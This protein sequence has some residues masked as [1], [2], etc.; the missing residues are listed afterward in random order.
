MQIQDLA[1]KEET[2]PGGGS[3][4]EVSHSGGRLRPRLTGLGV[5]LV[6]GYC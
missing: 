2:D 4:S 5:V 6:S 3:V 1:Q